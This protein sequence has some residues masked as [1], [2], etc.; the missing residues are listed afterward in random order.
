M[1]LNQHGFNKNIVYFLSVILSFF[2]VKIIDNP[3]LD[4]FLS[5]LLLTRYNTQHP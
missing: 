1:T 3:K 4:F 2:V 5:S